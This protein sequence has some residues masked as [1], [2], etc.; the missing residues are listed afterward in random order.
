MKEYKPPYLIKTIEEEHDFWSLPKPRHPLVSVYRF[1]NTMI[2]D[3]L[4]EIFMFDFYCISIKKNFKGK[5]IYGQHYYDFSSGAMTFLAPRQSM[6]H[7]RGE[8]AAKEGICLVFHPDFL[9]GYPLAK[10]IRNYNFFSYELSE[11]LHLS[12]QEQQTIEDILQKIEVEY[13]ANIDQFSQDVIIAQIE[14]LL[15]YCNRFYN[16]QFITRKP[17]NTAIL[18]RLEDLLQD[19]INSEEKMEQ[20]IPT[21]QYV[22]SQLNVS[23]NYLSDMLRSFTGQT[24]QQHIHAKLIE[25][26]KELL[27]TSNLSVSEIAYQLGFEYPQSFNKLFKNK[28]SV[29]PSDF[30]QSF[31]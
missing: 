10:S 18:Q 5:C 14:L 2:K 13:Q 24:T 23:P 27:T 11:A 8:D 7:P 22:A 17:A 29:S 30:R 15:Q 6:S 20:G 21:V 4:P 28:T 25:K 12:D 1:E 26:A 31:S 19:Y 9:L 16:R 3:S